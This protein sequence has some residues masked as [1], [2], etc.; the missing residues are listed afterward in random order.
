MQ[1][2]LSNSKEMDIYDM[3]SLN[4]HKDYCSVLPNPIWYIG[5]VYMNRHKNH[6][7]SQCLY[8]PD[9]VVLVNYN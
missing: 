2:F 7:S 8:V 3:P 4:N 9:S 6:T 1:L 5:S